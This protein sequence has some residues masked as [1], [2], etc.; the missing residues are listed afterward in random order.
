MIDAYNYFGYVMLE[1]DNSNVVH[2]LNG[3]EEGVSNF[4]V[5]RSIH[6]LRKRQW[7]KNFKK[8]D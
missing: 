1:Y 7:S 8:R 4:S 2:M 5:A 3:R 6:E